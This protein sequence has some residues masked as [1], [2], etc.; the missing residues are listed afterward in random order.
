MNRAGE[1]PK[2]GMSDKDMNASPAPDAGRSAAG[3]SPVT[4][5]YRDRD[6]CVCVKPAGVVSEEN[7]GAGMPERLAR[8]LGMDA[9]EVF[10]VHRLD[11][12]T[13]GVMV[14]ALNEKSA[15]ALSESVREGRLEK[16][17]RAAVSGHLAEKEGEWRDLLYHDPFR[18][19][20]YSV[21]RMRRGVREA[22][23]R[24]RVTGSFPAKDGVPG[25]DL[26]EISLL[27]GRTHQ[28]RVQCASR[29]HPLLGDR[30][31][32]S[33]ADVPMAL[34]CREIRFPHPADGAL[35]TFSCPPGEES[36]LFNIDRTILI[37][38]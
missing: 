28:I 36:V 38:I 22:V 2:Y 17:Y 18:N 6:I 19:K 32:G 25:G 15:A 16:L 5:L 14:Y 35:R 33:S 8:L 4:V 21:K 9:E 13:G 24:Y 10:P 1:K 23:L 26:L 11:R 7:G 20:S 34:W 3:E 30:R 29:G 37:R 31:Y 12:E 27:T